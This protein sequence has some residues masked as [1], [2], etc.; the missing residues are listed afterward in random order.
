MS[1]FNDI[2]DLNDEDFLLGE[3]EEDDT[4]VPDEPEIWST[5]QAQDMWTTDEAW[6]LGD[7]D[8]EEPEKEFDMSDLF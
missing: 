8:Y 2:F 1:G 5:G 4:N 3:E 7:E 6:V